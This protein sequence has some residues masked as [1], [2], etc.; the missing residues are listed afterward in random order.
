ML[1]REVTGETQYFLSGIEWMGRT[2]IV[3]VMCQP[4]SVRIMRLGGG[5]QHALG[6]VATWGKRCLPWLALT[7][8]VTQPI[9]IC[10]WNLK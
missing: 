10:E 2:T 3:P 1:V 7:V 6:K 5:R 9:V 8:S 4:Y